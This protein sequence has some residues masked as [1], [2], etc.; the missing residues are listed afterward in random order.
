MFAIANTP[1]ARVI[2][3][4]AE[5]KPRLLLG[6]KASDPNAMAAAMQ[7]M[8]ASEIARAQLVHN[9]NTL[10]LNERAAREA[11]VEDSHA[12][13]GGAQVVRFKQR[14]DGVDV[15]RGRASVVLDAQKNLVSLAS[16]LAPAWQNGDAMR[17]HAKTAKYKL[18]AEAAVAQAYSKLTNSTI[19]A[20]AVS[21]VGDATKELRDYKISAPGGGARVLSASA[22]RV[23]F[24]QNDALQPAY[25]VELL[26]RG[27]LPDTNNAAFSFVIN[28]LD[29]NT[30]WNASLTA[31]EKF[32][33]RV[34]ATPEGV[35]LDGPLVDITP[36]P[37]GK[38][39]KLDSKYAEP[40][41]VE[42]EGFNK[43]PDGKPDP[44]LE[45]GAT[46]SFGNNVQAY[47]DRNN[48]V[49]DAGVAVNNGFDEVDIR[50]DI[51][52]ANTFDRVY[53]VTKP[54]ETTDD[55][56]KAAVTQIF[57]T[58]NWL[59]DYFYDSGF[60]E[61]SG[62]AQLQNYGRGGEEGDPL[63][64]EAQDSADD[65]AGNNANMSTLADGR[66]PRMQMYVWNGVAN[67]SIA[68]EPPVAF[69]DT[70]GAASYGPEIFDIGDQRLPLVLVDDGSTE[71]PVGGSGTM[72]TVSDGCQPLAEF[73]D[74]VIA[75]IDRGQCPFVDKATNAQKAGAKAVLILDNSPGHVPPNPSATGVDITI[76]VL[77][78][79][80]EDATLLKAALA[81]A[82][83][84]APVVATK[85]ERGNEVKHDGTID[86]TVVAHE[87]GHY[88]HHRLVLC[89]QQSCGGMSEGFGD[90]VAVMLTIRD[91]D[92]LEN[93][94]FPMA[95][96]ATAG[97]SPFATYFGIRRAPYSTSTSINPFTFQHV[98][99]MATLPTGAPLT[100]STADMSE[101]HNVGEIWAE[102]LFEA[103]INVLKV[104]KAAGRPFEENKRRMADY[105]IAGL[106]AT[107]VEPT[108]GEQRDA[109]LSA[110]YAMAQG[111][112]GRMDDFLA[113]ARGFAKRGLGVGAVSPPAESLALDEAV[114]SKSMQGQLAIDGLKPDD[115]TSSCDNDGKLDSG[116]AG[117]ITVR[118][119]NTGW[120]TLDNTRVKVE[121]TDDA[122]SFENAGVVQIPS[123]E[124]FGHAEIA[125][126]VRLA[127]NAGSRGLLK[128]NVNAT[129]PDAYLA[130][131]SFPSEILYNYDDAAAV[132]A[133]DDMESE[134]SA[135]ALAP[136]TLD[137]WKRTGDTRNHVWHGA[138]VGTT[139]DESL[140]SP[141]LVV[142]NDVPFIINITHRYSFELNP[143]PSGI[144]TVPYDGAVLEV[145]E[146]GGATWRD[147]S[148][149]V[150]PGYG[151]PIFAY[152]EEGEEEPNV[153]A[154]R[155]AWVGTSPG[156]P[157]YSRLSL[158]LGDKL[159]GQ[160][161]KLRFRIGTDGGAGA[162]GWDIDEI[163][164]GTSN[165]SSISNTPFSGIVAN[166]KNCN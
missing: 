39:E 118:V 76:P 66:S 1:S 97:S 32:G 127:N 43:N 49:N 124:P 129:N 61:A 119:N 6:S 150:D 96:Y 16:S 113:L 98:R 154:K 144:T 114:E 54:P 158:D 59:H 131:A 133:S 55:Q 69:A 21:A 58:T 106:K 109:I 82:T 70:I 57:Y 120:T 91:G 89:G 143:A 24:S 94:A 33:Y 145:S 38:P 77:A 104:G 23:L 67:R 74:D 130:N 156:Y 159:A 117:K 28:A 47:S 14:V 40:I 19:D 42:T 115:S 103:Y 105:L 148:G 11:E 92:E 142:R 95:Q 46:Y 134:N 3:R 75:V 128:V 72:G 81:A 93:T 101:V 56:I 48:A 85:F 64:A 121:S 157:A 147:I 163:S 139:S 110:T 116:E 137:V 10:Q 88:L 162:P 126:N 50:A 73:T 100:S 30:L 152:E 112:A 62:N 63:L 86:N 111:D 17:E 78:L 7:G 8:P 123:I 164:F 37:T 79:S 153:L 53:D 18:S 84:D 26:I 22:K 41:L 31:S 36:H 2:S 45:P 166:A 4:S 83:A 136:K 29:G 25:Q 13:P 140:V 138:D 151:D 71:I 102:M 160:T 135:W 35:P 90:F 65:G 51:T 68:T 44:W 132:S 20:A 15:F 9:A 12:L 34:W 99:Q 125:V 27:P 146:D 155:K 122:I 165:F 60:D 52:S 141:D 149:Y 108:F 5:G 107:P 161:I 80:F 87:W